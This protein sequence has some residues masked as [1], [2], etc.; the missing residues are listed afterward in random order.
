MSELQENLEEIYNEK[1]T[2]LKPENIKNGVI[3]F[4][5]E[6]TYTGEV[7]DYNGKF[8][9][10][11]I[12]NLYNVSYPTV[13]R[14]IKEIPQIDLTGTTVCSSFFSSCENL[15]SAPQM[16]TSNITNMN[17]M[18]SGCKRMT[19]LYQYNTSNVSTMTN[20]CN[21][22]ESLT[23]VPILD[24]HSVTGSNMSNCFGTCPS[25]TNESLN[26]I[27]Y[28]CANSGVTG[29]TY[30]KLSYIGLSSTQATTCTGLSNWSACQ[31]AGWTTGY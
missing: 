17:S 6:G 11:A 2:Y 9:T 16:N 14:W 29:S 20:F 13:V 18:F 8:T 27:L 7:G 23:T 1:E 10:D 15:L 25:L 24:L 3:I 30:K 26:N 12:P 5:V 22:C 19:T 21:G 31:S 28:M 4:N